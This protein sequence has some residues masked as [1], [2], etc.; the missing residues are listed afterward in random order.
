MENLH[1]VKVGEAGGWFV[2]R[3][4]ARD[5]KLRAQGRKILWHFLPSA[6]SGKVGPRP[7]LLQ[8]LLAGKVPFTVYLP[9]G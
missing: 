6:T 2:A 9:E 7:S 1:E 8:K 5:L 3:K 4:L